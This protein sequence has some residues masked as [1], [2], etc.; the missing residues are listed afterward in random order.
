MTNPGLI[1]VPNTPTLFARASSS[2]RFASSDEH[3]RGHAIS[4]AMEITCAP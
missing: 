3:A 4:S 2:R 1:P